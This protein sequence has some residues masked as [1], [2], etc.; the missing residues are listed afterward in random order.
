MTPRIGFARLLTDS[1]EALQWRSNSAR[2]GKP[3][4]SATQ[5]ILLCDVSLSQH[6]WA[7][8]PALFEDHITVTSALRRPVSACSSLPL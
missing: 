1:R 7:T 6:F 4:V 8:Y 2:P 3:V 5:L